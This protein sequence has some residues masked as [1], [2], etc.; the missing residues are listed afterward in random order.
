MDGSPVAA[1]FPGQGQLQQDLMQHLK[2]ALAYADTDLP[3]YRQRIAEVQQTLRKVPLAERVYA[4]LKQQA[5][6]QLHVG[7]DLRHQVGPAF[8]VVYQSAA[9]ARQGVDV[10]LA[11]MLTA[12]GFKEYFEPRSQRFADL[13]M[14]DEWALGERGQLDYS[15]ADRAALSERLRN[16]YSADFIDSW[17][18]ALNAFS[19]ADFR[20]LDHGVAILQQ[21]TGPAAPAPAVGYCQG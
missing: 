10:L 17:R 11:P 5:G 3:Q 14:V 7:L 20:D 13:A 4:S 2:Y 1:K 16:L 6:E 12:K 19:V 21:F 18:R 8:D 15:D 9:G